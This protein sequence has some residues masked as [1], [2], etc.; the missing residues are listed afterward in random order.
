M[1]AV[2]IGS[3]IS[4]KVADVAGKSVF[5]WLYGR[6]DVLVMS[7]IRYNQ[8]YFPVSILIRC[9]NETLLFVII[10]MSGWNNWISIALMRCWVVFIMVLLSKKKEGV[11]AGL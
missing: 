8:V 10:K 9:R 6:S 5:Q 11:T 2:L 1:T 3:L 7:L 4:D